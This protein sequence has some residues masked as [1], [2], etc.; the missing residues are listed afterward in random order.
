MVDLTLPLVPMKHAYVVTEPIT[1]ARGLP[2]VRDHDGSIYF[3]VNGDCLQ[4]GGYE[5]NP[6][7]LD[8]VRDFTFEKW[9]FSPLV[10]H[11][12]SLGRAHKK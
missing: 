10:F 7:I 1:G 11:L 6:V 9:S 12:P 5:N 8:K 2:N 4:M 3:R